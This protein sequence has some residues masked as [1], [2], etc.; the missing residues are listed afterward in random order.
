MCA[1]SPVGLGLWLLWQLIGLDGGCGSYCCLTE[2]I[3]RFVSYTGRGSLVGSV[4]ASYAS[5][6][7]IDPRVRHIVSW[8]SF[9]SSAD[10]RRASC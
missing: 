5:G 10:S 2:E 6:P 8:K 9:P 7:E 1:F 3:L 4:S